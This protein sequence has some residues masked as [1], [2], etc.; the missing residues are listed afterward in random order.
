MYRL[1]YENLLKAERRFSYEIF[2]KHGEN[3][4]WPKQILGVLDLASTSKFI[5]RVPGSGR[6]AR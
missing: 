4:F 6:C 3:K 5:V 1:V 2:S